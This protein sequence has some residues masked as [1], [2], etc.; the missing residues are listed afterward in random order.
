MDRAQYDQ[1]TWDQLHEQC[2]QRGFR[3]KKSNE[4]LKTRLA[5]MDSAGA[6]RLA[7]KGS[8]DKNTPIYADGVREGAPAK[9]EMGPDIPTQSSGTTRLGGRRGRTLA[10]GVKDSDIPAQ[11]FGT[12]PVM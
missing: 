3:G 9:G 2:F 1:S 4:V 12:T 5:P 10:Q 11:L 6:T 8:V 7:S